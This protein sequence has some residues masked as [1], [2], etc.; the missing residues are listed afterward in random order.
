MARSR[1]GLYTRGAFFF[2]LPRNDT[3]IIAAFALL[4]NPIVAFGLMSPEMGLNTASSRPFRP[5]Q[6]HL[7]ADMT[8]RVNPRRWRYSGI[9]LISRTHRTGRRDDEV[10]LTSPHQI[11]MTST[12]GMAS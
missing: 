10:G 8:E 3:R 5:L 2:R 1:A 7:L 12:P 11:L 4:S 6:F 9:I